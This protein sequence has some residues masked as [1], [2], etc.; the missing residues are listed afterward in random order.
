MQ[1]A[2][3]QSTPVVF[4]RINRSTKAG[5]GLLLR[6]FLYSSQMNWLVATHNFWQLFVI[7]VIEQ[8]TFYSLK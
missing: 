8:S 2:D 3:E 4:Y 5:F 1:N 7:Q 6:L